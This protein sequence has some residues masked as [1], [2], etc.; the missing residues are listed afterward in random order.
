[1][2]RAR[3]RAETYRHD[4][5]APLRPDV[6]THAQFKPRNLPKTHRYDSSLSP[7][8]D[9]DGQLAVIDDCSDHESP[10]LRAAAMRESRLGESPLA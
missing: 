3:R 10:D 9:W 6:G 1:M 5:E 4:D 7:A 8:L 2:S